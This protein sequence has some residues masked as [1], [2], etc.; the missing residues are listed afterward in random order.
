[1]DYAQARIQARFGERPD[2]STWHVI[3]SARSPGAL[4]ETARSCGLRRWIAGL[5]AS[6]G[7]H[8]I[9]ISL[10]ARWRECIVELSSWMPSEWRAATLWLSGL[11]DLPALCH[12]ARGEPPL[13]WMNQ[14]PILRTYCIADVGERQARLRQDVLA[15][16]ES[17]PAAAD[18]PGAEGEDFEA[19]L[20]RAW[21]EQWRRLW[22]ARREAG[23]LDRLT[24]VVEAGTRAPM[25]TGRQALVRRLR[26]LFR[27]LTLRPS[28]AFVFLA[29]VAVDIARLRAGLLGHALLR[30]AGLGS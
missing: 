8:V 14:D 17:Q 27:E 13:A 20:R 24:A 10:R 19:Q 1:M 3:E 4:L 21:Y 30:E 29:L 2:E 28:A 11:V 22:P 23:S 25:S 6:C 9:E 7:S 5:D 12:L 15:F 16:V 26:A 18:A